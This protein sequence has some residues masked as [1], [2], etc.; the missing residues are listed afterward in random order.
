MSDPT[1]SADLYVYLYSPADG[2][3]RVDLRYFQPEEQAETNLESGPAVFDFDALRMA[4][5]HPATHGALLR[6]AVF[7]RPNLV[8]YYEK[9]LANAQGAGQELRLRILVDR[10][11]RKLQDL[12]WETLRD[13]ADALFL[14]ADANRPFSRFLPS[15]DWQRMEMRS[16]A[17]LRALVFVAN[18]REL[19]DGIE[20]DGQA[21]A[22]VPVEGEVQRALE[23]LKDF[24]LSL[25]IRDVPKVDVE[26]SQAAQPGRASFDNLAASLRKGYDILYLVCHGALRPD[27]EDPN[28]QR[29]L[30]V[31][32]KENGDYDA[33][34]A[35]DLVTFIRNLPAI[36]RPRLVVL[37]SCQSGG[38]GR[39]PGAGPE[40]EERS[41]DQGVL[42]ALGPRLVEAGVPAV[43]AMQANVRM[44]TVKKFTPAFFGELLRSGQVDKAMAVARS[45]IAAEPDWW[46][47][48]LYLR[49]RSGRLWF[50]GGYAGGG[51]E[52][53]KGIKTKIRTR[54]CTPVLGGGLIEFLIGPTREIARRWAEEN[55]YPF[56]RHNQEEMHQ[57]AEFLELAEGEDALYLFLFQVFASELQTRFK[58]ILPADLAGADP[59]EMDTQAL[60]EL[61]QKMIGAIGR[62][63]RQDP[64]DP[65]AV[66]ARLP[67][68]IYITANPDTLLEDALQEQGKKVQSLY[69]CWKKSLINNT[70]NIEAFSRLALPDKDRP[71]VYHL[72]GRLDEPRSL[73]LTEDDYFEYLMWIN[74][75]DHPLHI[76]DV[77]INAWQQNALLFLGF[78]TTDWNFRVLFRSILSEDRRRDRPDI[79]S[80]AVQLQ[81]G[82]DNL[83]PDS[84]RRYLEKY[85]YKDFNIYWGNTEDFLIDLALQVGI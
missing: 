34:S 6:Q 17:R 2:Q 75:T 11:A 8:A 71:L 42:A 49:L 80:V 35:E 48:V 43:V 9:S 24:P 1:S 19:Q 33:H 13:P 39:V 59:E 22:E 14:A 55:R 52:A 32:E 63:R 50:E 60:V 53:W 66:L 41:Y 25:G 64:G 70:E 29:P 37:A 38:K 30:I 45:V 79:R 77:V 5:L 67:V 51:F 73:V 36:L 56:Q 4:A 85:F 3:Y 10:S 18:P 23:G 82:D 84:A 74:R 76:P 15:D 83:R 31:L 47:P 65:F 78:Q 54:S 81:P 27:R 28:L 62:H 26:E 46:V 12:R 40:E 20:L 68:P 7:G 69:F 58:E 72:F 44:A 21:L 16:R 61:C 57:V